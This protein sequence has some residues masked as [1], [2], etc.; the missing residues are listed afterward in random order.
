MNETGNILSV[1]ITNPNGQDDANP[2]NNTI[3]KEFNSPISAETVVMTCYLG[4]QYAEELSWKLYD[5]LGNIVAQD[6][7]SS[8]NNGETIEE[9]FTLTETGCYDLVWYDSYG[10]GFNGGGWCKLSKDDVE[11]ANFNSFGSE[12]ATPWFAQIS[13][14]LEGTVDPV[15]T[16]EE[17]TIT[18]DW[19]SPGKAT[20]LGYNIYE[21]ADMDNPINTE[22][23]E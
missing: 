20:L 3:T 21:A 6:N 15:A 10:D 4:S 13:E 1:T 16:I 19:E 22:I 17:Y 12:K 9:T 18:F 23:I 7:Y 8:S 2:D 5:P 14:I 11:F